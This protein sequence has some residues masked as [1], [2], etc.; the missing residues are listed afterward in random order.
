MML[1]QREKMAMAETVARPRPAADF[2]RGPGYDE[3]FVLWSQHQAALIRERRFD[4][5]DRDNL[6]DEIESLGKRDGRQ[7]GIRVAPVE[8]AASIQGG[9]WSCRGA[10]AKA[11]PGAPGPVP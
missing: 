8:V 1:C 5:V 7:F 11:R 10:L 3:D 2:A 9:F 4:L 6:A